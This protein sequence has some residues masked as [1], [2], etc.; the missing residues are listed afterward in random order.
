M[1]IKRMLNQHRRDFTAV[2]VCESCGIEEQKRGYDD[3][4]FHN[5]VIPK[6]TCK[7]CGKTATED[8][9]PQKTK[10]PDGLQV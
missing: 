8:Y 9:T 4:Y 2:F 10:Y 7:S 3:T 5:N 1:K 6:M